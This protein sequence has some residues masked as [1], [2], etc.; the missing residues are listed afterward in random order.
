[1]SRPDHSAQPAAVPDVP[2]GSAAE[3]P[4]P[5]ATQVAAL[6]TRRK[7]GRV[8]VLMITSR[9]TRRW[10]LP[11]GWLI[12]GKTGPESALIEAWEEAGVIGTAA[13]TPIGSYTYGKLLEPGHVLPCRVDV[14]R[15]QV[16]KLAKQ[17]P[18]RAERRRKWMRASKAAKRVA[19]PELMAILRALSR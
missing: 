15:V 19:E 10:I 8:E 13:L 7:A 1:M 12:A 11:K 18:E 17:F 16:R 4:T 5:V 3:G 6:C 2:A 9:R 14:Y